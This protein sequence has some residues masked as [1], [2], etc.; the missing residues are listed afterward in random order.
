MTSRIAVFPGAFDPITNGHL[1]IIHRAARLFDRVV[2]AVGHNPD[3]Q[4]IFTADERVD[5]IESLV[6]SLDNV[7]VASYAGLT[8]DFVRS[9][10]AGVIVRGIRNSVDLRDE[11]LAANTNLIV[12]DLE[13]IFLMASEQFAL[14]S[15]TFIKQIIEMGGDKSTRLSALVPAAVLEQM[16]KKVRQGGDG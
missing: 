15:S 5:M 7:A 10:G 16:R 3:K 11:L 8:V 2:V 6:S 4:E 9:V 1:D 12:G 13:T 14:T